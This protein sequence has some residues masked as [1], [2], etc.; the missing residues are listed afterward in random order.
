MAVQITNTG[1]YDIH[2]AGHML[3]RTSPLVLYAWLNNLN[4]LRAEMWKSTDDG[5]NWSYT[6]QSIAGA[7]L[8]ALIY[9]ASC[10]LG[11]A[12]I[13]HCICI[14]Y[15][16][17][18]MGGG[19]TAILRYNQFDTSNDTFGTAVNAV[20][21]NGATGQNTLYSDCVQG[22]STDR[23]QVVVSNAT[24]NRLGTFQRAY[25]F[26]RTTAAV[27]SGGLDIRPSLA[28]F[29]PSICIEG[30][31]TRLPM[32]T[33]LGDDPVSALT[34]PIITLQG[35]AI[36]ATSF[37]AKTLA[38]G[39]GPS[40]TTAGAYAG[41]PQITQNSRGDEIIV[42]QGWTGPNDFSFT[43]HP[44]VA[45]H[46]E[47]GTWSVWSN[48]S[49]VNVDSAGSNATIATRGYGKGEADENILGYR[50]TPA[51]RRYENYNLYQGSSYTPHTI[52]GAP[53]DA[54]R[55]VKL[56]WANY[57]EPA[58]HRMDYLMESDGDIYYD[59]FDLNIAMK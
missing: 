20:T 9:A 19:A 6:G 12:G 57:W 3:V 4:D 55:Y 21:L 18:V 14:S 54:A 43:D 39:V 38:D 29:V 51:L 47:G 23:F 33:L 5:L 59:K 26:T 8:G 32:V 25:Y 40:F 37:A 44:C 48:T 31:S 34:V 15:V 10:A 58:L 13:I 41:A 16:P 30:Q 22:I 2:T 50:S 42:F 36:T 1:L 46:L 27:W 17:G 49:T 53:T 56:R 45:K 28:T 7:S 35:N 24:A 52:S 11:A